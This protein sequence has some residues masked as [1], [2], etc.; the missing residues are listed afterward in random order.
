MG[1]KSGRPQAGYIAGG[2]LHNADKGRT[3]KIRSG[4]ADKTT[5]RPEQATGQ[6]PRALPA[7]SDFR[8][9]QASTAP[10]NARTGAERWKLTAK[11]KSRLHN[12]PR[13]RQRKHRQADCRRQRRSRKRGT[14]SQSADGRRAK[15]ARAGASRAKRA[16]SAEQRER[17]TF[18]AFNVVLHKFSANNLHEKNSCE[19]VISER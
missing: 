7:Q 11:R 14:R 13:R 3:L 9:G 17:I 5:A 15:R 2:A 1:F 4:V 18:L 16:S 19:R 12:P 10:E 8:R 6:N